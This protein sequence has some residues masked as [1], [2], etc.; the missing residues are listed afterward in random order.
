MEVKA[1]TGENKNVIGDFGGIRVRVWNRR[2]LFL[3]GL[4]MARR[5]NR[6]LHTKL[7]LSFTAFGGHVFRSG[8]REEAE[9]DGNWWGNA[10]ENVV[11]MGG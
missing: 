3:W 6:R 10:V 4:L 11:M 9:S 8:V 7:T 2:T 5:G 1:I